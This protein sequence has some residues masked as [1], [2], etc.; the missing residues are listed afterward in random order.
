MT[1]ESEHYTGTMKVHRS[2]ATLLDQNIFEDLVY[3]D[4]SFRCTLL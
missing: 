4:K 1:E 2:L 3:L